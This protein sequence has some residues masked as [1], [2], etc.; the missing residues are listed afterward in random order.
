MYKST[1]KDHYLFLDHAT[2]GPADLLNSQNDL[3]GAMDLGDVKYKPWQDWPADLSENEKK[4]MQ[5]SAGFE[6]PQCNN[7]V[8]DLTVPAT[9]YR[10]EPI[11]MKRLQPSSLGYNRLAPAWTTHSASYRDPSRHPPRHTGYD[12]KGE[13]LGGS[14]FLGPHLFVA[15]KNKEMMAKLHS[16][17]QWRSSYSDGFRAVQPNTQ[18]E[19]ISFRRLPDLEKRL[20][21]GGGRSEVDRD[22]KVI[23]PGQKPPSMEH[24]R[25]TPL[26]RQQEFAAVFEAHQAQMGVRQDVPPEVECEAQATEQLISSIEAEGDARQMSEFWQEKLHDVASQSYNAAAPHLGIEGRPKVIGFT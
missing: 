9:H 20:W 15:D 18:H 13:R 24:F 1:Y 10:G 19:S 4:L 6:A 2:N 8:D 11:D 17:S 3:S 23:N 16:S 7:R 5:R 12:A 25:D 14:Q 22:G 21:P 26:E